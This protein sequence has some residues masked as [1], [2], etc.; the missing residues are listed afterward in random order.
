MLCQMESLVLLVPDDDSRNGNVPNTFEVHG[1]DFNNVTNFL[2]LENTITSPASHAG[3]IEQ[4]R[5]VDHMV[6]WRTGIL[7]SELVPGS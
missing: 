4:L 7:T 2:A 1:S 3:H 6:I 5:A